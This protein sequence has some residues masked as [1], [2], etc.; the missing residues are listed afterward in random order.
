MWHIIPIGGDAIELMAGVY[1]YFNE[2]EAI[3]HLNGQYFFIDSDYS[4]KERYLAGLPDCSYILQERKQLDETDAPQNWVAVT[5]A[6]DKEYDRLRD[7][8]NTHF[9]NN[10][11]NPGLVSKKY[12]NI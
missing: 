9:V 4:V 8:F 5:D 3:R 2:N 7:K 10:Q 1:R 11:K 12:Q 6:F